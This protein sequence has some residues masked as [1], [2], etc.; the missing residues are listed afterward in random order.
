ML[1]FK[2]VKYI[3][4]I[5]KNITCVLGADIGGTNSNFGIFLPTNGKLEL[6]L[7]IH[8]KSQE[9]KNFTNL[10]Q[11]FLDY[12]KKTYQINIINASFAAA[13]VVSENRDFCKPTNL[14]FVLD[15]KEIIKKTDLKCV[16][17]VN[18][19]EI[20]GYGLSLINKNGIVQINKGEKRKNGTKCFLF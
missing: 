10:V 5:P 2:E 20:I 11:N 4:K 1:K 18:D 3:E 15:A 8:F 9:I 16:T 17:I 13:G 7:S 19:F 12:L 14:D 6:L